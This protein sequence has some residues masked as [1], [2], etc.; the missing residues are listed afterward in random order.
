MRK[1]FL[2]KLNPWLEKKLS[3]PGCTHNKLVGH[4]SVWKNTLTSF[5]STLLLTLGLL[6]FAP[7]LT[8]LIHYGYVLLILFPLTLNLFLLFPHRFMVVGFS[9]GLSLNLISFFFILKLGGI[10]TSGGLIFVGLS[11]ALATVPLQM[12]WYSVMMFSVYLFLVVFMVALKPWLHIPEQ[13]TPGLNSVMFMLN[14]M[15]T[16]GSSLLFVLNFIRQ[17]RLYDDLEARKLKE[18]NEAKDKLFTNITH[19]FRTPLTVIQGMTDLIENS[20]DEWL[21]EGTS[22]IRNNSN[23]LLRLVNQMLDLA[24]IE[25]GLLP[26]RMVRGNVN[27]FMVYVTE[28]FGSVARI[29]EIALLN[30]VER[31]PFE[32]DYDPDKLLQILSNLLSNALKF[33][34]RGGE[35]EVSSCRD[36]GDSVLTIIVRD[37]GTGIAPEHLPQIFERFYQGHTKSGDQPGTGLGLFYTRELVELL[38]GSI[39]VKSIPGEGTEFSVELPVTRN[40]PPETIPDPGKIEKQ[41]VTCLPVQPEKLHSG[42]EEVVAGSGLPLML[43]VEDSSEVSLYL[44]AILKKEYQ[45]VFAENG[46][47]GYEKA[48]STIPDVI[49]SDVMMPEM[50]GIEMLEKVKGDFRTSHIPVVMLTA[51]A[52]VDS[53]LEGLGKGADAYLAKPFNEMELHIVLKNLVEIRRKLHERYAVTNRPAES[54]AEEF[55]M[56]DAFMA[57]VRQVL[58]ANLEDEEF[59][60][61]GLCRELAV[62]RTQLYRKFKSLSNKTLSDYFKILRLYKAR[63]LLSTSDFNVTEICFAV[64]FKNL[65]YFSREFKSEFGRSPGEFRNGK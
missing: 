40:A 4:Q 27:A 21:K 60:V 43:I 36:T 7:Q 62:S 41:V 25:S 65:S 61:S 20:P 31:E 63:E 14:T 37:T 42:S 52:D 5:I 38:K 33:T 22:R 56:E 19:E 58:E 16:A 9:Q 2:Q 29:R 30:A 50:D 45:I 24:R 47:A 23:I 51:R 55:R 54:P 8:L 10:P 53:R 46:K 11:V 49:L 64:G 3:Y 39:T 17:Q 34:G 32:M 18:I 44:G 6:I 28:L 12:A 48:V 59:G 26:V 57:K 35:V 15:S 1:G 13:M